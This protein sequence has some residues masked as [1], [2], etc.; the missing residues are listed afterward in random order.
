MGTACDAYADAIKAEH[1]E[2]STWPTGC[3][4]GLV[5]GVLISV[6]LSTLTGGTETAAGLS[7]VTARVA[8]KTPRFIALLKALRAIAE[9]C[10]TPVR[11]ARDALSPPTEAGR[12]A[13]APPSRGPPPRGSG[14]DAAGVD[15]E[16]EAWL[17]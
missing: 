9:G 7:A 13:R 3:S 1:A 5:E 15:S 4:S 8:D 14:A 2:S 12:S 16:E 10:A 17:R 11:A 6:A